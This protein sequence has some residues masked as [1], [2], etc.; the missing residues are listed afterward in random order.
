MTQKE[1]N[2][3]RKELDSCFEMCSKE[4][5]IIVSRLIDEVINLEIQLDEIKKLPKYK[6]HP[7]HPDIIKPL[8][9][10]KMQKDL[11]QQY[12]IA[13]KNLH[14]MENRN[15]DQDDESPL[16]KYLRTLEND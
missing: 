14:S 3:R 1:K 10:F 16:R 7:Q 12:N 2:A 4:T 11:M 6:V 8:P 5:K 13:I 15:N 9:V